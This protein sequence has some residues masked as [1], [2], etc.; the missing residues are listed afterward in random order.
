MN[1]D[2]GLSERKKLILRYI[3]DEYIETGRPVSSKAIAELSG[4]NLSAATIRNEMSDLAEMG[5]LDQPHTSSGRIPSPLAYRI[6]VGEL[7]REQKLSVNE[8]KEINE[9]LRQRLAQLDALIAD[10]THM[11]TELTNHPAFALLKSRAYLSGAANALDRPG[12]D[13]IERAR[14]LLAYIDT[15]P[16]ALPPASEPD[17]TITT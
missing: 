15:T 1:T 9:A 12:Y 11:V 6:Y 10:L 2:A 3:V 8:T 4:L 13:E 5:L 14:Q 16:T 7:M 17:S